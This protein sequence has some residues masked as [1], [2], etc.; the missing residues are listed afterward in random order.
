MKRGIVCLLVC[1]LM[2][3]ACGSAPAASETVP[4]P[5]SESSTEVSA[6]STAPQDETTAWTEPAGTTEADEPSTALPE[7]DVPLNTSAPRRTSI[8]ASVLYSVSEAATRLTTT[9]QQKPDYLL[10]TPSRVEQSSA[11]K[12]E[13]TTAKQTTTTMQPATTTT[14]TVHYD[15]SGSFGAPIQSDTAQQSPTPSGKSQFSDT[16]SPS[17]PSGKPQ[18]PTGNASPSCTLTISAKEIREHPEKLK[19][20]EKLAFVPEDG[21]ILKS[22]RMTF[23]EGETVYDVL[24]RACDTHPCSA[25]CAFCQA[26]GGKIQMES[27]FTPV[28]DSYYVEGIH[29]LYEKDCGGTSGWTYYVNGVFPNYGS[30]QYKLKDGDRIEWVYSIE[31]D[32]FE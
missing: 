9:A 12:K 18:Q 4:A 2:L 19:T 7:T 6:E 5:A 29:Q 30:S 26:D 21:Y 15:G 1:V 27:S 32:S 24:R 22:L 28:Y 16:Q 10:K 20:E 31:Q 14:T 13:T 8:S 17:T 23:S 25:N 3:H 11:S